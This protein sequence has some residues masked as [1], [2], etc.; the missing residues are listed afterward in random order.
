MRLVTY[1]PGPDRQR[2]GAL[3]NRDTSIVDLRTAA[4][5][6]GHSEESFLDMLA[7]ID[8]GD[9][10]VDLA[11]RLADEA[12]AKGQDRAL[13]RRDGV[14]LMAPVPVP[15]QMRDFLVFEEHLKTARKNR[16]RKMAAQMPDPE[17]AFADFVR[18][19]VVA[20][21]P[22]WYK[23]PIYYKCNRFSVVGTDADVRWPSYAS[24]LD[25]ELEFGAFLGKGGVNISAGKAKAHIFGYTIFNDISARD[26]QAQEMEGQL[27]PAKGKD[28]DTG[29]VM[30]PCLVTADEIPNA[31][32]L[33]MKARVNG[34]EWSNGNSSTMHYTF[35]QIIEFVSR[36]ETLHAGEFLG[37]GTV[38]GGCGLEVNRWLA[39][40]D[41][42]ELEVEKIGILRN[43]IMKQPDIST[44][45]VIEVEYSH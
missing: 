25:Y 40:N 27:G 39:P 26:A 35:E 38:G 32:A 3:V 42:I 8:G 34:M 37:S 2:I 21:P 17:A 36:D 4:A 9:R 45:D 11:R 24:V 20:P 31:Y 15:R 14:Q 23:Q 22:I 13:V 18:R 19:G 16:F 43:R 12:A 30:G 10:A 44:K 6:G 5:L 41:V 29:N 28:F 1:K 7:L 33:A